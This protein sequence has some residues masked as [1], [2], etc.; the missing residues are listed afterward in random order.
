VAS[1]PGTEKAQPIGG[2]IKQKHHQ[3]SVIAEQAS[4]NE[5]EE[6]LGTV[7]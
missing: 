7:G 1:K 4:Q 3:P 6:A 5:M 2:V